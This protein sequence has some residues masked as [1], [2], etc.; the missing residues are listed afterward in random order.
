MTAS[1]DNNSLTFDSRF[2]STK[3]TFIQKFTRKTNGRLHFICKWRKLCACPYLVF[4]SCF[5]Q[6]GGKMLTTAS[7]SKILKA[8]QPTFKILDA[9]DLWHSIIMTLIFNLH[10]WPHCQLVRAFRIDQFINKFPTKTRY[11]FSVLQTLKLDTKLDN[12]DGK[13]KT[14][15]CPFVRYFRTVFWDDITLIWDENIVYFF[16][17]EN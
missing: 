13:F 2:A 6:L 10:T 17:W 11:N 14:C 7:S 15:S 5:V 4:P 16:H 12:I 9:Y 8:G 1:S 3:H